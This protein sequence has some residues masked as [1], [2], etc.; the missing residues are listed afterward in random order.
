MGHGA[1]VMVLIKSNFDVLDVGYVRINLV[2]NQIKCKNVGVFEANEQNL[3]K[4]QLA[5]WLARS[6]RKFLL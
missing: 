1:Y 4:C 2:I 6:I 3:I 5:L